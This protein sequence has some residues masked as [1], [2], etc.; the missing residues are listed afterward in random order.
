VKSRQPSDAEDILQ[1]GSK[2]ILIDQNGHPVFYNIFVN[3]KFAEFVRT[4]HYNDIKTLQASPAEEELPTGVVEYK[5]SWQIV[6]TANPPTDRIVVTAFVPWLIADA[7]EPG[8]LRVDTTRPLRPVTVALIGLHVVFLPENHPEM[9]WATFEY[10]RNAPSLKGNPQSLSGAAVC[11]NGKEPHDETV[12]DD[13]KPYVL[14]QNGTTFKDANQKDQPKTVVDAQA[15]TFSPSTSIVR[16]FP[17]SACSPF[18]DSAAITEI[19]PA[20]VSI[21]GHV[22]DTLKLKKP[23]LSSYS[24]VAAVWQDEPRSKD[25]NVQF[26]SDKT[27]PDAQLGGE[28]RLSSSS[29]E[30]F[31][32]IASP[33][34]FACH[35]TQSKGGLD[36]KRISVSHLFRRFALGPH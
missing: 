3:P 21:N 13:G 9:I 1:A 11:P 36:P 27:F 34:C 5:A 29:M 19:D 24:L 6:D 4:K 17:F 20:I 26:K 8:K 33:N 32:Q 22:K 31:T 18:A 14:Y 2:A 12:A 23:W 16:A 25:P 28:D 30:S 15:Q 35:D 10:D 7:S